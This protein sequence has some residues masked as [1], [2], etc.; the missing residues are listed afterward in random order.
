MSAPFILIDVTLNK[1]NKHIDIAGFLVLL[2]LFANTASAQERPLKEVRIKHK[3]AANNQL[4]DERLKS[5][6]PGMKILQ[7]DS[8]TLAQ[9]SMQNLAQ[10]LTQ[11]LPVFIKSYGINSIATLN[12]RGSSAAQSQVLWNGVPLNNAS[13]GLA[14]ISLLSNS[15]FERINIAYGGSSALLGSGNVGAAILLDNKFERIDSLKK[16]QT[17]I[18]FEAGSFNQYKFA[19]QEQFATQKLFITL[20]LSV[21]STENNFTY[22][23]QDHVVQ[24]M[25]N[26]ALKS[27]SG[28][29]NLGYKINATTQINFSLW[30]Q[31]FDREIPPA[32]FEK[33]SVKSQQ[34]ASFKTLFEVKK[35]IAKGDIFYSR[36]SFMRDE[37]QYSDSASNLHSN[38]STYQLYQEAGWKKSINRHHHFIVFIPINIAWTTPQNDSTPRFQNRF[39]LATSYKFTSLQDRLNTAVNFRAEQINDQ[40]VFLPGANASYQ[41][42]NVL[43][44]RANVQRSYRV[45]TLNEWYYQ[46]GGN[47]NLK[48]EKGWS[49]DAGYELKLPISSHILLTHDLSIFNRSIYNWIL[50]FGG[51][52]WTPHN[53][54]KVH[55]RGI[56]TF[57]SLLWKSGKWKFNLG[58]NTSFVLAT[59]QQSDIPGDGSIGKQIPYSPRYNGQANAGVG[60]RN[61]LVNYNHTYTGYRFTTTDESQFLVP[62]QTGNFYANYKAS[63]RKLNC[64]LSFYCNNLWN[65][66]YKVVNLRPM[67]GRNYAL[68]INFSL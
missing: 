19:V 2:F 12:F 31:Y 44:L 6:A 55:S 54:A 27:I 3:R 29:L 59:T 60:Y 65:V 9:Y 30:Q 15:N 39:A 28:M 17:N 45:P 61:F 34:D 18:A 57:N 1:V 50:W 14:D 49:E 22:K 40:S 51:S 42:C 38:N 37:M 66:E 32:L 53:I 20:K 7:I 10:L 56:E 63:F 35:T 4:E 5:F 62:Y 8:Q 64:G 47:P 16:I 67:P 24:K 11:Q 23:N 46:P 68:G 58:L 26:A 25:H 52:I 41:L 21:Q 36:T 13:L 33:Y 48:P 43:T